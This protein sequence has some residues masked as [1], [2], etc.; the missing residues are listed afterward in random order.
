MAKKEEAQV[1]I[2]EFKQKDSEPEITILASIS[3]MIKD[4]VHRGHSVRG[5]HPFDK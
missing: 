3:D 2:I 5:K 1:C 4:V